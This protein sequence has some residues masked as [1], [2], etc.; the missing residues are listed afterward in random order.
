MVLERLRDAELYLKPSKYQFH[1]QEVGFLGFI[2]GS[3][4]IQMDSAKVSAITSWPVLTSVHDIH[5]FLGLANFYH[6]FIHNFSKTAVS[7][8]VLLKKNQKFQ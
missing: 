1:V 5:V 3:R 8:T 2:V 7:I 4:G 6:H